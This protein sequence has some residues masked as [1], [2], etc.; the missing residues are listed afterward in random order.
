MKNLTYIL[1]LFTQIIFAQAYYAPQPKVFELDPEAYGIVQGEVTSE[2]A[3]NNRLAFMDAMQDAKAQGYRTFKTRDIDAYFNISSLAEGRTFFRQF[4]EAI[5]TVSDLDLDFRDNSTFRV[6]P[7][8]EGETALF[9]TLNSKNITIKGGNFRGDRVEHIGGDQRGHLLWVL[10][11]TNVLIDGVDARYAH[12]DGLKVSSRSQTWRPD[13][14]PS[15]NVIIRNSNFELNRRQGIS[16]TDG[17]KIIVERNSGIDNGTDYMGSLGTNPKCFVDVESERQSDANGNLI[18]NEHTH[19]VIIRE[20]TER[21][22]GNSAVL[23]HI[24]DTLDVVNNNFQ[25]G[26]VVDYVSHTRVIGNSM[27]LG[28]TGYGVGVNIARENRSTYNNLVEGNYIEGNE[29]GINLGGSGA[30]IKNNTIINA[31]T[32][33]KVKDVRNALVEGNIFESN[34]SNGTAAYFHVTTSDSS[35]FKNNKFQ[36]ARDAIVFVNANNSSPAKRSLF[37]GNE[38]LGQRSSMLNSAGFTFKNNTW[39]NPFSITSSE[40]IVMD[41]QNTIN[42][43]SSYAL[44]LKTGNDN[45][46]IIDNIFN[47]NGSPVKWDSQPTN[48]NYSGNILNGLNQD[49]TTPQGGP[50]SGQFD[51]SFN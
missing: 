28:S 27:I 30:T 13:Y 47:A 20:N 10:A 32:G 2:Q 40:N 16:L 33:L 39:N 37:E 34:V 17:F 21:G 15:N 44:D 9:A 18:L 51:E 42:S 31:A 22:S 11:G 36:A 48:F 6:F 12:G 49:G 38:F 29:I 4:D 3:L 25:N 5:K 43:T 26:I 46:T 7:N 41:S 50:F 23:L 19:T 24:G 1:L 35:T 8:D 14:A 45:I